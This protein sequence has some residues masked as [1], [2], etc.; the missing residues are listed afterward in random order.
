M[1]PFTYARPLTVAD[2]VAMLGAHPDAKP[3][4][5]G[6]TLI[7]TL[8]QR[9]ARPSH[10]IDL[11]RLP[12]LQGI[13]FEGGMLRVGAATPHALIAS[14]VIVRQ[15]IP[16]LSVL[17][18][19]I[20]DVQ[21]RSRGTIGGSIANNDPAA[22]Y[23]GAMLGLDATIVTSRRRIA[24][25]EFFTGMF[26]TALAADEIVV[27]VECPQPL[28]AAYVKHRHPASGYSVCGVFVA[29]FEKTTRVAITGAAPC[30][31]RWL[32]AEARLAPGSQWTAEMLEGLLLPVDNLNEDLCA[33]AAY[34]AHLAGVMLRRA[35]KQ[36]AGVAGHAGN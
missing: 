35:V 29:A 16:A 31:T 18:G 20:G 19:A 27:A 4:L 3:L 6:M 9:L 15:A 5:G 36:L 12:E 17:A 25:L 21:V 13:V 23:P 32:E 34:R 30:V 10:L 14:S 1:Y 8:K 24:A 2:A 22:D 33:T 7:P 26:S 11:S 28:R